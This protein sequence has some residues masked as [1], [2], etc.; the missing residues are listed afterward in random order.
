M[1]TAVKI[2]KT[3]ICVVVQKIV[4]I[5]SLSLFIPPKIV[6]I[7]L[8]GDNAELIYE[9]FGVGENVSNSK[10]SLNCISDVINT[11]YSLWCIG[12]KNNF[13]CSKFKESRIVF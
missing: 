10:F 9:S 11:E 3:Y 7:I 6:W 4:N 8:A 12:A 2:V 5:V 1:F 13:G